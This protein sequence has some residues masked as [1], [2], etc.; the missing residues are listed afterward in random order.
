MRR[1][2]PQM[3]LAHIRRLASL[4]YRSPFYSPPMVSRTW[5]GASTVRTANIKAS[6]LWTGHM[7]DDNPILTTLC[8]AIWRGNRPGDDAPAVFSFVHAPNGT[9]PWWLLATVDGYKFT[10]LWTG[11][12]TPYN[13]TGNAFGPTLSGQLLFHS[14]DDTFGSSGWKL[15][16]SPFPAAH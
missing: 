13:R 5:C 15:R 10:R 2:T 3:C 4:R 11:E 6:T 9:G 16:R 1:T 14:A 8:Q 12:P 7:F